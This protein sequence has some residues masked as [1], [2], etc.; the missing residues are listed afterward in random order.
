[1][2]RGLPMIDFLFLVGLGAI[3]ASFGAFLAYLVG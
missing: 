3:S 2:T 1:M